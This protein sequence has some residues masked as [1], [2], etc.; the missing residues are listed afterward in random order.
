MFDLSKLNGALLVEFIVSMGFVREFG[1]LRWRR[2][3]LN[4][5]VCHLG[6][7]FWVLKA[8]ESPVGCLG[9]FAT[10][11]FPNSNQQFQFLLSTTPQT[12][13][14]KPYHHPQLIFKLKK[15]NDNNREK[16]FP[17]RMINFQIEKKLTER[18]PHVTSIR[19]HH[20]RHPPLFIVSEC[21]NKSGKKSEGKEIFWHNWIVFCFILVVVLFSWCGVWKRHWIL[22]FRDKKCN[23]ID[24]N[25][26]GTREYPSGERKQQK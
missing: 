25:K 4:W 26:I 13:V 2:C 1:A 10:D 7:I 5:R 9:E 20:F 18:Y 16:L 17:L 19:L 11:F 12:T 6:K 22:C 24:T 23:K 21:V 15:H 3:Y 8:A 14:P